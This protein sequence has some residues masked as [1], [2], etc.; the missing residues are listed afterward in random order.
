MSSR[1]EGDSHRGSHAEATTYNLL[2][3]CTGNTCRSPM[4]AAIAE[5]MIARRGW[6]NVT[7][8]SAGAN[9]GAGSPASAAAIDVAAEHGIDLSRHRSRPLT[10]ELIDW[11]DA[12]IVMSDWHAQRIADLGGGAKVALAT[13][14]LSDADH[15]AGIPDPIGLDTTV[16][17]AT[18]AVL[19]DVVSGV[20]DRL[21][22]IL[23]P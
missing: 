21:E 12:I 15:A 23:A 10:G 18:Y 9:A 16:Y 6:H 3:V 11:A 2:F 17:R 7:V 20:L 1:A 14:F 5:D 22:A 8:R 13:E 19:S 4:A